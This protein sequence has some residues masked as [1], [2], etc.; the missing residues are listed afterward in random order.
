MKDEGI[1]LKQ[2][3]RRSVLLH[4]KLTNLV[5]FFEQLSDQLVFS[6]FVYFGILP[7][8][9]HLGLTL[10]DLTFVRAPVLADDVHRS[11]EKFVGHFSGVVNE[12]FSKKQGPVVI[13]Q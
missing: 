2:M 9:L 10:R 12:R 11:V 8:L 1:L 13:V 7:E 6:L 5:L 4:R 3:G